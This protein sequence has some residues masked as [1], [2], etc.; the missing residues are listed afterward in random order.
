[1]ALSGGLNGGSE[2]PAFQRAERK[3]IMAE[4][5]AAER[6]ENLDSSTL[7]ELTETNSKHLNVVSN[8][9]AIPHLLWLFLVHIESFE[10][11]IYCIF[12]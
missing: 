5:A 9:L 3:R 11:F 12:V 1:M 4:E 6:S 10:N 7:L 8:S 2:P